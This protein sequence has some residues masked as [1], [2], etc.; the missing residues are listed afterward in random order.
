MVS[1]AIENMPEDPSDFG[2]YILV[3]TN[4]ERIYTGADIE[5]DVLARLD[6]AL[7]EKKIQLRTIRVEFD[8]KKTTHMN[9]SSFMNVCFLFL[10]ISNSSFSDSENKKYNIQ[11][12]QDLLD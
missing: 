8:G 10:D 1:S 7:T 12:C 5:Q 9:P 3:L 6:E 11:Y 2:R 4:L